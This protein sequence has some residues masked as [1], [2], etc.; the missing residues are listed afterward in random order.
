MTEG[1][2]SEWKVKEGEPFAAGDVLLS[3]ETD[4]AAIDV[5]AQDDGIMGKILVSFQSL[6][7]WRERRR[8]CWS[9]RHRG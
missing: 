5:E 7:G 6:S 8:D 2:I 1:S 9:F 3:V 4:K